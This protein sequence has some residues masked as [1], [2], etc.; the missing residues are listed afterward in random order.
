MSEHS[1]SCAGKSQVKVRSVVM[2]MLK[3]KNLLKMF[4]RFKAPSLRAAFLLNVMGTVPKNS[5]T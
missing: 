3:I 1:V 5:S 4:Y 2:V